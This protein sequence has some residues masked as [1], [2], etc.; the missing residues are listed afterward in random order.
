MTE[1]DFQVHDPTGHS[2]LLLKWLCLTTEGLFSASVISKCPVTFST[3]IPGCHHCLACSACAP[4]FTAHTLP[5][6]ATFLN[7]SFKQSHKDRRMLNLKMLKD[8]TKASC[9]PALSEVIPVKNMSRSELY[10]C[11]GQGASSFWETGKMKISI[12][13]FIE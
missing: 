10:I 3:W 8:F 2:L 13:V 6:V 7:D 11:H 9:I 5:S 1:C 4:L 12:S